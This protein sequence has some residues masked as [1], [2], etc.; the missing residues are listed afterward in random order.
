[1]PFFRYNPATERN[2]EIL[3]GLASAY[4]KKAADFRDRVLRRPRN[5]ITGLPGY[6][7]L[8]RMLNEELTRRAQRRFSL[9]VVIVEFLHYSDLV[10]S[11]SGVKALEIVT[12]FAR[13]GAG[14]GRALAFHYREESQVVFVLPGV[15]HEGASLFCLGIMEEFNDRSWIPDELELRLEPIYGLASVKAGQDAEALLTEAETVLGVSKNLFLGHA[16][17]DGD[18]RSAARPDDGDGAQTDGPARSQAEPR[19]SPTEPSPLPEVEAETGDEDG[20]ELEEL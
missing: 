10:Y 6:G 20:A 5:E 14:D 18:E 15:D 7:E 12:S 2:L 3:V 4:L 9:S 16:Q 1:M 8:Q 17:R 19:A 11:L 13:L